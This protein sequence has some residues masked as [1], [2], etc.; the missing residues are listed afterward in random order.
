MEPDRIKFGGGATLSTL[1]PVMALAML[2]AILLIFI[3]PRSRVIIPLL[4][5]AFCIPLGQVVVL[6]GLHFSVLRIL[7]LCGCA[8]FIRPILA[9]KRAFVGGVNS[10]DV[11]MVLYAICSLLT[12]SLLYL[13]TQALIK[14]LGVFVE[15]FGGY[16]LV[17]YLIR[18]M[19]DVRLTVRVLVIIAAVMSIGMINERLTRHNI[20]WSFGGGTRLDGSSMSISD[21]RDGQVR[22]QGA[23]VIYLLAGAFGASLMPFAVW[24][25]KDGSK[26]IALVA[27][28]SSTVMTITVASS[29]SIMGYVAGIIGLCF[30]PL[31]K[32]MR[33]IRWICL[34]AIVSLH[35]AM[36]APVWH[37]ISRLD[38]TGSSSSYHRYLL[39]DNFIRRFGDWWL[40]GAKDT[41]SWGFGMWDTCNAYVSAGIGG[42]LVTFIAF[43]AVISRSFGKLGKAR[44]VV[45][46]DKSDKTMEWLVWCLGAAMFDQAV[47]FLGVVY[48]A[49]M[50]M[51]WFVFLAI[52][53]VVAYTARKP[54]E[55]R[56]TAAAGPAIESDTPAFDAIVSVDEIEVRS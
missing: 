41:N 35:L 45:E 11:W 19:R 18:D 42:G 33:L 12:F 21:V 7:I 16:L 17:R 51:A 4:L 6:G 52:I 5:A 32:R 56:V 13:E 50:Q 55:L 14:S 30:W 9:S 49:Q 24:L 8:R 20:F 40:L 15:T 29:T 38:L 1:H 44:K 46:R 37:L 31:R 48:D 53:S 10:I 3:L 36:K 25:W 27:L 47:G 23:F 22:A 28:V 26:L 2:V 39:V 54:G 43:V 34:A